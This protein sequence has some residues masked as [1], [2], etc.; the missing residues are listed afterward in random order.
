MPWLQAGPFLG[1]RRS[2]DM[3]ISGRH[4]GV[5]RVPCRAFDVCSLAARLFVLDQLLPVGISVG[6]PASRLPRF[7]A[8]FAVHAVNHFETDLA[9]LE[10]EEVNEDR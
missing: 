9:A 6:G 1:H 4:L 5:S 7:E 8:R 3:M 2:G 10:E